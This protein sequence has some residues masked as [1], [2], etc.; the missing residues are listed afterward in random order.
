MNLNAGGA[1]IA[2]EYFTLFV[3]HIAPRSL[4]ASATIEI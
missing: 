1:F 4:A 2:V 3:G